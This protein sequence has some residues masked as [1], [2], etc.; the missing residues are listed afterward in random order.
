MR[1]PTFPVSIVMQRRALQNRW[2]SEAWE[3]YAVLA[4]AGEGAPRV[5]VEEP[6][7]HRVLSP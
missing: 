2:Q 7:L 1:N 4:E 5:L 6:D 3:P